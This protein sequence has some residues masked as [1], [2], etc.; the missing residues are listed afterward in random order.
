MY[1][2]IFELYSS[3]YSHMQEDY[4]SLAKLRGKYL[5]GKV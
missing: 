2:E 5:D 4:K 3:L 1:M